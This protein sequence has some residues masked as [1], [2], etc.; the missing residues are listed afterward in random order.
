MAMCVEIEIRDVAM[1]LGHLTKVSDVKRKEL[2]LHVDMN[3]GH[4][5]GEGVYLSETH[6]P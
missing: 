2:G 1:F 6:V 4:A 3:F 5:R